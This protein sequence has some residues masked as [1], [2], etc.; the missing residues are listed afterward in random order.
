LVRLTKGT[1]LYAN[2]MQTQQR[3]I[4]LR[5]V[6]GTF[7]TWT[8]VLVPFENELAH[9]KHAL[10]SL[11]KQPATVITKATSLTEGKVTLLSNNAR[12][13]VD[14]SAVI[15]LNKNFII[16]SLAAALKGLSG[17][18]TSY[19]AQV[20]EGTTISFSNTE[21][22]KLLVGFFNSKDTGFLKAPELE[23]NASAND[24][25]QAETK[26]ANAVVIKGLPPVNIH[27]YSFEPGK[28]MLK[29]AKG[30]CLLLGFV[31]GKETI[32]MYDACL[33]EN[34]V[35]KEVDWLFE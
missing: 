12:Y 15:F 6:N 24:Y 20:K 21:P 35:K 7:K 16:T 25:G 30:A 8:E 28:H 33:T 13:T 34:G 3:K 17:I 27:S 18:Q 2:S 32:P 26:I 22:V 9:F 23:T 5:G 14:S 29:L 10:D 11:K 31:N 1:Y 19:S 4:P